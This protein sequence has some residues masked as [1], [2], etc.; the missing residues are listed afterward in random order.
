VQEIIQP[1]DVSEGEEVLPAKTSLIK[2]TGVCWLTL[3]YFIVD[4]LIKKSHESSSEE[5]AA[6]ILLKQWM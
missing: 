5:S 1:E 6:L 4:W 3:V 2:G